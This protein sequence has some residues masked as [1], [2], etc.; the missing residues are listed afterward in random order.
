M[1]E[2][3]LVSKWVQNYFKP[4]WRNGL[5][6]MHLKEMYNVYY[7]SYSSDYLWSFLFKQWLPL[8]LSH[9]AVITLGLLSYSSDY[10]W[11]SL[12]HSSD[13]TWSS[14]THWWVTS[15]KI[16]LLTV[17]GMTCDNCIYT[18]RWSVVSCYCKNT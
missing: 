2:C 1:F 14:L 5:E 12:L 7:L 13:Y 3:K 4:L 11:S 8:V 18:D 15:G 10:P 17:W 9:K 6:R 16:E